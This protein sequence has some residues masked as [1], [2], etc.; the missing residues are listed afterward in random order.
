MDRTAP[1][2]VRLRQLAR[3]LITDLARGGPL[4][5]D[6]ACLATAVGLPV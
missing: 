6:V 2:K 1:A 5:A 4:P 3:T